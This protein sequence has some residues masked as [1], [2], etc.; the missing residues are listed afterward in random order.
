MRKY[1]AFRKC[2]YR[3]STHIPYISGIQTE[4]F[5]SVFIRVILMNTIMVAFNITGA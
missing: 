4:F 1:M 5:M 3:I 2:L